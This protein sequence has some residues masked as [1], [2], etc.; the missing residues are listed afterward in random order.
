MFV[1]PLGESLLQAR[2]QHLMRR[3]RAESRRLAATPAA[4]ADVL[5]LLHSW[6]ATMRRRVG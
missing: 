2:G 3:K 4:P 1:T 6:Q 5:H